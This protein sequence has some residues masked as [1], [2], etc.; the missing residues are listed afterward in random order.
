MTDTEHVETPTLSLLTIRIPQELDT[1]IQAAG[2]RNQLTKSAVA[3]LAIE[4]GLTVLES[5]LTS[6][7]ETT[8]S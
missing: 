5:Q 3:R 2:K 4:R 7:Y 1:A 6:A 8:E